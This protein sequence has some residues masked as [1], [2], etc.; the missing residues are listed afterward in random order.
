MT[1]PN[2]QTTS[3]R[4]ES[5]AVPGTAAGHPRHYKRR[6]KPEKLAAIVAAETTSIAAASEQTGIPESTIRYWLEQ[7]QFAEF[8]AK[9][10]VDMT[11][12]FTVLVHLVMSEI[13]TRIKEFE[14]EELPILLGIAFD[15][16]QLLR[17]G[18]TER[19]EHVSITDGFNDE[20]KAALQ[21]AIRKELTD[22][23]GIASDS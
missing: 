5:H 9:T 3:H 13:V 22:R 1:A 15:K 10:Q 6:S 18:V 8:R 2:G 19:T 14:P 20:E 12:G 11:E 7:P 4:V 21:A 17:G 23:A 16:T